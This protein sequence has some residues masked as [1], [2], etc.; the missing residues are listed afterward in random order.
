MAGF[1]AQMACAEPLKHLRAFRGKRPT[2]RT[3]QMRQRS[4]ARCAMQAGM[5]THSAVEPGLDASNVNALKDVISA[6]RKAL[7]DA[8]ADG[9]SGA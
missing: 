9:A 1:V 7:L 3:D 2:A 5:N 6:L 8:A 4:F